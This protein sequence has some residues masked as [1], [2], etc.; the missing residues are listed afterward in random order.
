MA[1]DVLTS[2]HTALTAHAPLTQTTVKAPKAA[3]TLPGLVWRWAV[4]GLGDSALVLETEAVHKYGG[5]AVGDEWR[6][7]IPKE[8]PG[9]RA[10][11]GDTLI[12]DLG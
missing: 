9:R 11:G 2:P 1:L 6:C 4:S 5:P 7:A 3:E 8:K 10:L 12:E